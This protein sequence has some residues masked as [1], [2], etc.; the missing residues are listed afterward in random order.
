MARTSKQIQHRIDTFCMVVFRSQIFGMIAYG[1]TSL[2]VIPFAS[3]SALTYR[4]QA[5][6]LT[7]ESMMICLLSGNSMIK[8]VRGLVPSA[9]VN[10]V[11][12]K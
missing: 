5:V 6:K 7:F 4:S 8:S 3:C 2:S 12:S 10:V 9:C 11:C 1:L